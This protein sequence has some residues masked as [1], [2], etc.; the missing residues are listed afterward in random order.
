MP[1]STPT[2]VAEESRL[3]GGLAY[4]YGSVYPLTKCC[5][6]TATGTADYIGC[7]RCYEPVDPMV[8]AFLA[9]VK[10]GEFGPTEQRELADMIR[11]FDLDTSV[12]EVIQRVRKAAHA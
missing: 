11:Y 8:G 1:T 10:Y 3:C 4:G 2:I 5:K 9:R 6:A 7:R 12:R